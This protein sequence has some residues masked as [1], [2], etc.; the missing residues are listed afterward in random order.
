M[1]GA[2]L[3]DED[4]LHRLA[5]PLAQLYRRAHNAKT[6]L[7]RHQAAY[8]LWEAALKLLG[9]VLVIEY[10]ESSEHDT[11]LTELLQNLARPAI[12]HW[13]EFVRGL[14]PI[15]ARTAVGPFG[16]LNDLVLGKARD[17]LPMAAGLD[18]RLSEALDGRGGTRSTVR[19]PTACR[20]RRSA[21]QP[22]LRRSRLQGC[23]SRDAR[24][25]VARPHPASRSA[26]PRGPTSQRE[27]VGAVA[28]ACLPARGR[29]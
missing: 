7:E 18:G 12:G 21:G 11:Q 27:P 15:L 22:T 2:H 26:A 17:D 25:G 19:A 6:P 3:C 10:A 20:L 29:R 9:S 4:L 14:L 1:N 8:Y 28:V 5:L 24:R 16:M 13:W 23:C